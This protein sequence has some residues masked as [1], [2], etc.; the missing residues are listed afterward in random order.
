MVSRTQLANV[1]K[2]RVNSSEDSCVELMRIIEARRKKHQ[3]KLRAKSARTAAP[4]KG[5]LKGTFEQV[6]DNLGVTIEK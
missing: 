5:S 4:I 2:F 6:M 3:L 1:T